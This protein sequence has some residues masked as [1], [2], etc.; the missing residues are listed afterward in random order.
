MGQSGPGPGPGPAHGDGME[1]E[2]EPVLNIKPAP[3]T[4]Q[5][6]RA[7][8]GPRQLAVRSSITSSVLVSLLSC[9]SPQAHCF[10]HGFATICYSM[11]VHA[12]P[13]CY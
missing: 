8:R 6:G 12:Q 1:R 7:V 11:H 13:R 9:S 3:V 2:T 5:V 10:L 4:F